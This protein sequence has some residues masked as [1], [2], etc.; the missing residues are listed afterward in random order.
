EQIASE[1]AIIDRGCVVVCGGLDDLKQKYQRIRVV[2]ADG[3]RDV[4]WADGAEHIRQVG[5]TVSILARRNVEAIL[6]QARSLPDTTVERHPVT[7]KDLFL[8]HVRTN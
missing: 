8:D 1:I 5:R 4:R 2:F 7:L 3:L 6:A